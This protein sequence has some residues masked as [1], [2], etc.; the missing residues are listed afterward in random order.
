GERTVEVLADRAQLSIANASQHLQQMKRAGLIDA[1]RDGKFVYYALS[2]DAVVDLL[3]AVRR[4]GERRSAEVA[5]V[6]WSYFRARDDL[7]PVSRA[8]L[9][10]R[11]KTGRVTLLDVRPEDEYALGHLPGAINIPLNTL[12]KRFADLD[13]KLEIV[14]YCRGPYCVLSFEAVAWLRARGFKV[15][16]LE[17]GLPEWRAAKLPVEVGLSPPVI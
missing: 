6:V 9:L 16:R 1:R 14:A 15:R 5:S 8:E 11:L 2:D 13:R 3:T 4:I 17:E 10:K 7:E 12:K